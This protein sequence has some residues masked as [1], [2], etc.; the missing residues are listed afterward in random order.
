MYHFISL[1]ATKQLIACF[2][3]HGVPPLPCSAGLRA[4]AGSG[5]LRGTLSLPS[6]TSF[7][8]ASLRSRPTHPSPGQALRQPLFCAE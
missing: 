6:S 1:D 4:A 2:N 3:F 8:T 7:R 5:L